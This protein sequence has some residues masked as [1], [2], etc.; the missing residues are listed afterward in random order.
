MP[1]RVAN[2]GLGP[3]PNHALIGRITAPNWLTETVH[4]AL[5]Q[6]RVHETTTGLSQSP[7]DPVGHVLSD[8]WRTQPS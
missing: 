5:I 4:Q 6:R 1:D 7:R 2:S 8:R 3:C